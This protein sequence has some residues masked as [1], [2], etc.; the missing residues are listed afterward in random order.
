[1]KKEAS[2]LDVKRWRT[3]IT[4]HLFYVMK[5]SGMDKRTLKTIMRPGINFFFTF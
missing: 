5:D 3:S 2:Y 4:A 1:M